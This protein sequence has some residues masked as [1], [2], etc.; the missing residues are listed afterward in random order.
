MSSLPRALAQ[1]L[2]VKTGREVFA[3]AQE[4]D[5]WQLQFTGA[6]PPVSADLLVVTTPAPQ[7]VKLLGDHR[8]A[9][10]ARDVKM[11]PCLTMMTGFDRQLGLLFD[12]LK[13]PSPELSWIIRNASKPGRTRLPEAWVVHASPEWSAEHLELD[14]QDFADLMFTL[15]AETVEVDL[16]KPIH[17]SGHRWRY[18]FA[19][20]PLGETFLA[21]PEDGLFVGG[22]WCLGPLAEDAWRSG[23]ALAAA[24][25]DNL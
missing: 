1:D 5:G 16:P 25:I 24:I 20:N 10:T 17:L 12:T 7:A 23:Q 14:K 8:L 11:V 18:A 19:S 3:I 13:A 22:D 9:T 2:D 6:Q 21:S 15:L 4:A